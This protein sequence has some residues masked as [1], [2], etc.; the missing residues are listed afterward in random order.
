MSDTSVRLFLF[1][2]VVLAGSSVVTARLSIYCVCPS[3]RTAFSLQCP[4]N[5]TTGTLDG[6]VSNG[7]FNKSHSWFVFMPGYHSLSQS[8]IVDSTVNLTLQGPYD[9][10]E[11]AT[12]RCA[13]SQRVN[14]TFQNVSLI[15]LERLIFCNCIYEKAGH[16]GLTQNNT[17][18]AFGVFFQDGMNVKLSSLQFINTGLFLNNTVSSIQLNE[19]HVLHNDSVSNHQHI[20][21]AYFNFSVCPKEVNVTISDSAFYSL[22]I[23]HKA[24]AVTLALYCTNIQVIVVRSHFSGLGGLVSLLLRNSYHQYERYVQFHQ[25]HF[26]Q[27]RAEAGGAVLITLQQV[28][29]P[30]AGWYL[31]RTVTNGGFI[32]FDDTNFTNN[33]AY[34]SGAA[35]QVLIKSS[36]SPLNISFTRCNFL[37]N[38]LLKPGHG[39]IAVNVFKFS[40]MQ[41]LDFFTPQIRLQNCFLRENYV[42]HK[43]SCDSNNAVM[44]VVHTHFLKLIDTEIVCNNCTAILAVAS[45]VL[46]EKN[47]SITNNVGSNGG[48]FL[49]CDD[50]AMFLMPHTYVRITNNSASHTG[51]GICVNSPCLTVTPMCFFQL[52][53]QV[54]C[55]H[56]LHTITVELFDNHANYSGHNLFGG[57]VDHCHLLHAPAKYDNVSSVREIFHEIFHYTRNQDLN[58]SISSIPRR[59]CF[60]KENTTNTGDSNCSISLDYPK[61]VYPG[62]QFSIPVVIVGQ[63]NGTVPGTVSA[64]TGDHDHIIPTLLEVQK[65][66]HLSCASLEYIIN[67]KSNSVNRTGHVKISLQVHYEGDISTSLRQTLFPS[68]LLTVHLQKCPVG[69]KLKYDQKT[70]IFTCKCANVF[71]NTNV[72]CNISNLILD[73]PPASWIGYIADPYDRNGS[74]Y[75]VFNAICPFDYCTLSN[76][77]L[78][79]NNGLLNQDSQCSFHRTGIL[80]GSCPEGFSVILGTSDCWKCSRRSLALIP[81]FAVMGVMLIAFLTVTNFTVSEGTIS[82]LIFYAN[83]VQIGSTIFFPSERTVLGTILKVF[84]SWISLDFGISACLYENMDTYSKAW[85][86]FVFPV[87]LWVLSAVIVFLCVVGTFQ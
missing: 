52:S 61:D 62:S 51:G 44:S 67:I 82:G 26:E 32:A 65:V 4:P 57:F 13:K 22:N 78:N 29:P 43:Y 5:S 77:S 73:K 37:G 41:Y 76:N 47:I 35:V 39:G 75:V 16:S 10:E 7:M 56:L 36:Y 3:N 14:I 45:N 28:F 12:I 72:I 58:S 53:E 69:F 59:V 42:K 86:Q 24:Q 31:N 66:H 40:T 27:G 46:L 79:V 63:L 23:N 6:F 80:C 84:I 8:L 20:G 81:L 54:Y 50:S 11:N 15:S 64:F 19:V 25:C 85:L 18:F 33:S 74:K 68:S 70:D 71:K 1:A 38:Y 34:Y 48:G 30:A 17:P 87:Y 60:C 49:F 55:H 83:V 2:L 9:A 21:T